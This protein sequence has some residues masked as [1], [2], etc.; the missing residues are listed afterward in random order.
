MSHPDSTR[1]RSELTDHR[2]RSSRRCYEAWIFS[3]TGADRDFARAN[4]I[5]TYLSDRSRPASVVTGSDTADSVRQVHCAESG[6]LNGRPIAPRYH[7]VIDSAEPL[8]SAGVEQMSPGQVREAADTFGTALRWALEG[9][10]LVALGNR[11]AVLIAGFRADLAGGLV[12]DGV[13]ARD[14]LG[15]FDDFRV[16]ETLLRLRETGDIYSRFL[17][18]MRRAQS[19]SALGERLQLV[20]YK[21]RPDLLDAATLAD[22]GEETH[23]TRQ[24]QSKIAGC[25][26]DTFDGLTALCER[27]E[28][29]RLRCRIAQLS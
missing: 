20:A 29:T 10:G 1:R 26:R 18:W 3:L 14:L 25:L 2:E 12:V 8:E 6:R 27:P 28:I 13:L 5:D 17:E 16:S 7:P 24:S 15:A 4:G 21:L 11:S 22:L 23:K 9:L 19:V